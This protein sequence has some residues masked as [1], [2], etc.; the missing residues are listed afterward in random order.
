M[1]DSYTFTGSAVDRIG[2]VI[3]IVEGQQRQRNAVGDVRDAR[4]SGER[5]WAKVG[6]G[7]NGAY[8]WV[9]VVPNASGTGFET[10]SATGTNNLHEASG[11]VAVPMDAIVEA[12]LVGYSGSSPQYRFAFSAGT[13][14]VDLSQ[15]GGDNTGWTYTVKRRGTAE[16]LDSGASPLIDI[17]HGFDRVAATKGIAAVVA[18]GVELLIAGETI[19][20]E[21]CPA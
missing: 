19:E 11:N 2:K 16:V 1:A 3:G 10:A 18:N 14:A 5:F 13:V 4:R 7:N 9:H 8:S 20:T 15:D 6:A 21:T 12:E 17:T